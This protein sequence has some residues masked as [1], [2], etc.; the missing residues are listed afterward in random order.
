MFKKFKRK[1]YHIFDLD[2]DPDKNLGSLQ[3]Q[4]HMTWELYEH[5]GLPIGPQLA[6]RLLLLQDLG[7]QPAAGLYYAFHHLQQVVSA[8]AF[9][10]TAYVNI[11]DPDPF[12][13]LSF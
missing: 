5:K 12:G 4:I 3:I 8:R 1:K 10:F 6:N 2:L 13:S 9:G 7:V 11:E